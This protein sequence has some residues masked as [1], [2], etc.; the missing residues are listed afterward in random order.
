M[1][2]TTRSL[3][4]LLA[5]CALYSCGDDAATF[6]V[7]SDEIPGGV[8]LGGISDGQE[9]IFVGGHLGGG[10]GVIAHYNDDG[11]C[12]EEAATD[13][14]LWWIHSGRPGEWYAVG[15]AGTIIHS[16]DGVRTDES[17]ATA[18]ILYGVWDA[19]D[20]VIAVG[21]DL[22]GT[23]EGEVWVR[24]SG[25]WSQLASG[26]PG[27][28]FKVWDKW[29]VGQDVAYHLE[30]DTLVERFPPARTTLLTVV[31]R[32]DNDV[33]AVGGPI[34]T[35]LHWNGSDWDPVEF[36]LACAGNSGLNGVWTEPDNSVWIAGNFGTMGEWDGSEWNCPK[37]PPTYEH[38]HAVV[39]HGDE[40]LWAGGNLLSVGNNY[41]TIGRF[42][43]G[44]RSLTATPCP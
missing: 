25:T 2:S 24:K 10:S 37:A 35:F 38:Y 19:G 43:K 34:P 7:V 8:L 15:E 33:W 20:R 41:G 3:A 11:L 39:K 17:V 23:G 28:V 5:C 26:L 14:A 44:K 13:R 21:G 31:G 1:S 16:V 22:R 12:V 40:M 32:N 27:V 6:S 36:D 9:V 4:I 30:G 42:G 18:A 29:L